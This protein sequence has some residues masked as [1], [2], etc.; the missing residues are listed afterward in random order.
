MDYLELAVSVRPETTEAIADV[1]RRYA[2]NGV[3]IEPPF[4]ALDEEG[5]VAFDTEAPLT[6]RAWLPADKAGKA[7]LAALLRE[8]RERE[9]IVMPLRA[10]TVS[11][12][13]WKDVWKRHFPV[14]RIG[15]RI[16][17]KPSW[18]THRRRKDDVVIEL[19]PG[20]AFGTGQHATTRLCLE[21][22]EEHVRPGTK[23]LDVGSGS[24][25]LSVAAALLGAS[26]VDALDIDPAAVRATKEN[27]SRNCV[28]V[29]ARQGSLGE[30]WPFRA[31]PDG[32]Y[33]VVLANITARVVKELARPI[34]AALA[35]GGVAIV[36]GVIEEQEASCRD[37]LESALRSVRLKPNP[38]VAAKREE[39]WV[40]L[41]VT[42][43]QA[44]A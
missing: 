22:L 24:G 25:I 9:G 19:D 23:V 12:D 13:S 34:V 26:Q 43:R 6:L 42:N 29:R 40:R 10:R 28:V 4:E 36:S 11:D 30:D 20:L 1:V 16:V 39:G 3:S 35:D 33:D 18:R 31:V 21:A 5:H 14:T 38:R 32:R 15:R 17:I 41:V 37:A 7:A 2:P 27:V 44:E 8:L